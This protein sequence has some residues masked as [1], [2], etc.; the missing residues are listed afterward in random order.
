[1]SFKDYIL[2]IAIALS[3][4][5]AAIGGVHFASDEIANYYIESN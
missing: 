3:L 2:V 1:M 4:S 5:V